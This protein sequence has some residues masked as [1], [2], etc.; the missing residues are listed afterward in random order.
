VANICMWS[1]NGKNLHQ[2]VGYR[3]WS[4]F[5]QG[6]YS[7]TPNHLALYSPALALNHF[8]IG[9]VITALFHMQVLY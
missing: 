9:A 7:N 8:G 6:L 1:S 4:W 5:H 3:F 2:L